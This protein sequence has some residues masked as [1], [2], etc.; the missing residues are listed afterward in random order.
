MKQSSKFVGVALL[1]YV[2]Q[3]IRLTLIVTGTI[4]RRMAHAF[5]ALPNSITNQDGIGSMKLLV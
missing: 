1:Y 3:E 5:N 4:S 2:F